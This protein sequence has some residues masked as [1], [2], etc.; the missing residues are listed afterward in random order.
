[1]SL[2]GEGRGDEVRIGRAGGMRR[3]MVWPSGLYY[4]AVIRDGTRSRRQGS[5]DL[6]NNIRLRLTK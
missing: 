1:M 6:A 5:L 2:N 4:N 3:G